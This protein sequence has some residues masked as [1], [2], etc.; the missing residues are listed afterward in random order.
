MI[1]PLCKSI[2][3]NCG[4][5]VLYPPISDFDDQI[6]EIRNLY[7]VVVCIWLC[8]ITSVISPLCESYSIIFTLELTYFTISNKNLA[9]IEECDGLYHSIPNSF[10][11]SSCRV[12][13][14]VFPD[15]VHLLIWRSL[16]PDN[17]GFWA[18][19]DF[20]PL[21]GCLPFWYG[22]D[23]KFPVVLTIWM[24]KPFL[25]RDKTFLRIYIFV[26]TINLEFLKGIDFLK[27]FVKNN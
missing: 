8:C 18:V 7:L 17:I 3:P 19:F 12:L 4:A 6:L 20:C 16:V 11:N 5:H 9:I 14:L 22:V 10:P 21:Q 2:F 15:G 26:W 1:G 24:N 27:Y 13:P 25:C 23:L